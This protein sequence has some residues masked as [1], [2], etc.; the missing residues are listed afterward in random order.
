M[1][2]SFLTNNFSDP[3]IHDQ[4]VTECRL[5]YLECRANC[6][7]QLCDSACLTEFAGTLSKYSKYKILSECESTCPCGLD[8]PAGCQDC[9][10]HPLCQDECEDAQLNNEEYQNCLNE[11]VNELVKLQNL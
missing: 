11:A 2:S 8:C 1:S 5:S 10:E 4:C 7:S 6:D 3:E 9:I